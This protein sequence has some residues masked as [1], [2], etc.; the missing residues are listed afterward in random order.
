MLDASPDREISDTDIPQ[1]MQAIVTYLSG[2][3]AFKK[4]RF[5]ISV[6]GMPEAPVNQGILTIVIIS[7]LFSQQSEGT[8]A[9]VNINADPQH[10]GRL[11]LSFSK[12]EGSSEGTAP[13][14]RLADISEMLPFERIRKLAVQYPASGVFILQDDWQSDRMRSELI[15]ELKLD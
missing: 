14:S 10:P 1:L 9:S 11:N 15:L 5:E 4:C 6:A 2:I 12:D 3:D 8:F 13:D 7:F